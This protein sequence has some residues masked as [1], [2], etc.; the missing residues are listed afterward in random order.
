LQLLN[1]ADALYRRNRS[2]VHFSVQVSGDDRS[3]RIRRSLESLF[4]RYDFVTMPQ[5]AA[6]L[7]S[8][9]ISG[10]EEQTA[11]GPFVRA[12]IS[13][14]VRDRSGSTILSYNKNY[15]RV[16]HST[17]EGAYSRA[18]GVIERDLEENFIRE[19]A[20]LLGG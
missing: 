13:L 19:L 9:A 6:Y 20:A 3:G 10:Q 11:V 17:V 15:P 2:G 8:A 7:V 16:S 18:F 12:G 1:N 4:E 14:R 5:N